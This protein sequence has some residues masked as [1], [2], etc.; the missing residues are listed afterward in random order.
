MMQIG[1]F[2][3]EHRLNKLSKLG[4]SLEKLNALIGWELFRPIL[5][6]GMAKKKSE[7]KGHGERP[8]YDTV[9]LFKSLVPARLFNL[10]DDQAEY[11]RSHEICRVCA[12]H[13]P[14]N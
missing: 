1:F 10:S 11:Q 14:K 4:D 2:N 5:S 6:Q 9:L 3:E 12:V 8:P 13:A 7:R